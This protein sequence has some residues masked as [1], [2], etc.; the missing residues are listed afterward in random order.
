MLTLPRLSLSGRH[1]WSLVGI[2]DAD[3]AA[4]GDVDVPDAGVVGDFAGA[5]RSEAAALAGGR[6][7]ADLAGVEVAGAAQGL[8]GARAE[9]GDDIA[10]LSV[11][12][13]LAGRVLP[14]G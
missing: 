9:Q 13:A 12:F 11:I 3:L 10:A 2:G 7:Q 4:L 8:R 1:S 5:K 14:G 6:G